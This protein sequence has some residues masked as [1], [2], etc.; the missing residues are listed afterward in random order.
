[1]GIAKEKSGRGGHRK[2]LFDARLKQ[3]V[4]QAGGETDAQWDDLSPSLVAGTKCS[5]G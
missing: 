2:Q 3:N 4:A 5:V 1:M